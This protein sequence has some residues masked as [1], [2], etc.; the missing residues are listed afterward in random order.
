[1]VYLYV[2]ANTLSTW[3]YRKSRLEHRWF[4]IYLTH[5]C[6][7]SPFHHQNYFRNHLRH[8]SYKTPLPGQRK[9]KSF[10]NR[11]EG[12]SYFVMVLE[13]AQLSTWARPLSCCPGVQL[14]LGGYDLTVVLILKLAITFGRYWFGMVA[15]LLSWSPQLL[16]PATPKIPNPLTSLLFP[17]VCEHESNKNN[18][19]ALNVNMLLSKKCGLR[20]CCVTLVRFCP[21]GLTFLT[22]FVWWIVCMG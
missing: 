21:Q 12:C 20:G 7:Q 19:W 2:G 11:Q 18:V 22:A 16:P 9:G 4:N 3:S 13:R 15:L 17:C 1:M 14:V 8:H 10:G 5:Y 6:V